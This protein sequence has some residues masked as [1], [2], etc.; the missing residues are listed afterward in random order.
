MFALY[1]SEVL[2]TLQFYLCCFL[3]YTLVLLILC[4]SVIRRLGIYGICMDL[5]LLNIC[6][7][8]T[9]HLTFLQNCQTRGAHKSIS[10]LVS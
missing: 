2:H 8:L 10:N 9:S 1:S 3:H 6:V 5:N 4:F 7:T